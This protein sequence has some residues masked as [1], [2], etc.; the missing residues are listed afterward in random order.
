LA[1]CSREI[2]NA[3]FDLVRRKPS[4]QFRECRNLYASAGMLTDALRR[5][6]EFGEERRSSQDAG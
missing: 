5:F 2:G 3:D 6:D 1:R 4:Q